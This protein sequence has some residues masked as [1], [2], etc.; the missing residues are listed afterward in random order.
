MSVLLS[1]SRLV[2]HRSV[3]YFSYILY[4]I[5][6]G[7]IFSFFSSIIA[8]AV[9]II[10]LPVSLSSS[11]LRDLQ[12]FSYGGFVS[13]HFY[14]FERANHIYSFKTEEISSLLLKY[15]CLLC[16]I[17]ESVTIEREYVVV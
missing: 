17:C 6:F 10:V 5:S 16:L 13:F 4:P 3:R 14:L 7:F 8:I 11:S 15:F 9:I 2:L 12:L 1:L